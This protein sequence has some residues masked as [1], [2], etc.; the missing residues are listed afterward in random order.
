MTWGR[1]KKSSFSIFKQ[2]GSGLEW[3]VLLLTTVIVITVATMATSNKTILSVRDH[4]VTSWREQRCLYFHSQQQISQ[5][6]RDITAS[7]S[8]ISLQS[9]IFQKNGRPYYRGKSNLRALRALE[10]AQN[11]LMVSRYG[12]RET[13]RKKAWNSFFGHLVNTRSNLNFKFNFRNWTDYFLHFI[14][15]AF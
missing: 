8:K 13:Q 7:Y 14:W 11:L 9:S 6:D 4:C 2:L 5:S 15:I 1:W 12:G 10:R 3:S